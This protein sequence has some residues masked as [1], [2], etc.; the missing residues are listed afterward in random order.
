M[1]I[2]KIFKELESLINEKVNIDNKQ[3]VFQSFLFFDFLTFFTGIKDDLNDEISICDYI[4]EFTY[5]EG[6]LIFN[7]IVKFKNKDTYL[8][9]KKIT[10]IFFFKLAIIYKNYKRFFLLKYNS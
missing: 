6:D 7:L 1:T 5:S 9:I 10:K 4:I 2:K 3:E 8:D